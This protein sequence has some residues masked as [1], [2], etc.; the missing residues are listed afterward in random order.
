MR[1]GGEHL[2]KDPGAGTS[3][4]APVLLPPGEDTTLS[5]TAHES[6]YLLAIQTLR[7]RAICESVAVFEVDAVLVKQVE[8][9]LFIVCVGRGGES[10]KFAENERGKYGQDVSWAQC[11]S[12]LQAVRVCGGRGESN[13]SAPCTRRPP[14]EKNPNSRQTEIAQTDMSVRIK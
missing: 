11:K 5:I 9:L 13:P 10:G 14:P 7:P 12:V 1:R 6:F 3:H 2:R 4:L 8:T